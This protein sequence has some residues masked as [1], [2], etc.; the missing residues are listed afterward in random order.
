MAAVML[1]H[2]LAAHDAGLCVVR[3]TEDGRKKP[4]G[5][6]EKW[7]RERPSVDQLRDWFSNGATGMG[8]VCGEV[9]GGLEMIE[10]EGRAVEDGTMARFVAAAEAA[11]LGHVLHHLCASF[12]VESPS[13]GRHLLYRCDE[14]DDSQKLA[15]RADGLCL[16]ETRGEGGFVV[17]PPSHGTVHPSGGEWRLLAGSFATIPTISAEQR[18]AL[19]DLARTFDELPRAKPSDPTAKRTRTGDSVLDR[20]DRDHTGGEIL[21]RNG[22]TFSH[23]DSNGN[24]HWTRPGKEVRKGTSATVWADDGTT[25]LWSTSIKAPAEF[26]GN[27]QLRPSQLAAALEHGGDFDALTREVGGDDTDWIDEA[28]RAGGASAPRDDD[29]PEATT[30]GDSVADRLAVGRL[31]DEFWAASPV[32][33]HVRH[34]AWARLVS[35]EAVL[36]AVL[37]RVVALTPHIVELPAIVGR[38]AGLSLLVGNVGPSNVGKSAAAGVATELVAVPAGLDVADGLPLGSGEGLA[39]MLMGTVPDVNPATGKFEKVRRQVRFNAFV[40]VDE[41]QV[42]GDLAARAG[43]T[44]APTIRT[45]FSHGT[46]G[47]ANAAADRTR[48]VAGTNYTFGIVLGL[49]PDKAGPLLA[50]AGGG[51]PQR[52]VWATAL[53]PRP[54]V[55]D[56]PGPLDWSPPTPNLLA[57]HEG[58]NRNGMRRAV[59]TVAAAVQAEIREDHLLAIEGRGRL[60][61][62]HNLRRLKVAAALALLTGPGLVIDETTWAL[63]GMLLQAS[64]EVQ[65]AM[66]DHLAATEAARRNDADRHAVD[67]SA[68]V[69]VATA[70][71]TEAR[72]LASASKSAARVVAKHATGS[73]SDGCAQRCIRSATAS[74]HRELVGIEAII[75]TAVA[76]GWIVEDEGRFRPGESRPA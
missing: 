73:C 55:V 9:S 30:S 26:I 38:W 13:G 19:L 60:G 2:A 51:T 64:T 53:A 31:P 43:S 42:L 62:H 36:V 44:L 22:F 45:I 48:I 12:A 65:A 46:I 47:Q 33:D 5:T 49:Q 52:F 63:A 25:T 70:S 61:E 32:L 68:K 23:S 74:K 50:D 29:E 24:D 34:A 41:G 54:P 28:M 67:R 27:R 21:E 17:A 7:Q 15:S 71:A 16:I 76:H 6:W 58:P 37:A 14:I 57:E 75:A 4:V 59:F 69:A 66:H 72:A 11:G 39:E 56:D 10:F 18:R 8:I 20:F 3:A 40:V 1:D 35:P